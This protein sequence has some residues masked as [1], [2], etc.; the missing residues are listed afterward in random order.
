ML[1]QLRARHE[2]SDANLLQQGL[3]LV[4]L[5]VVIVILGILA[6]VVVFAVNGIQDRGQLNA[7]KIDAQTVRTAVEAYRAQG[8][9]A[10]ATANP[11]MNDLVTAG[12]ISQAGTYHTISYTG[13]T[14]T[15][16]KAGACVGLSYSA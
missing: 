13:S 9:A 3:T 7:C 10:T 4:E 12:L 11:T 8:G 1:K 14:L 5:L 6:T 2:R 15:L 16:T